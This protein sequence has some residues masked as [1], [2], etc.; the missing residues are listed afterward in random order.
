MPIGVRVPRWSGCVRLTPC[1]ASTSK[2]MLL[3]TNRDF[4]EFVELLNSNGVRFLIVGGHAVALHGYPR[5]TGDLDVWVA[6]DPENA[7]RVT[8]VLLEFGFGSLKFSAQDFTRPGYAIQLGRPPYRI[9]ILT[10]IDAVAFSP[11]YRRR[12]TVRAGRLTIPFIAL[13]DLLR[14]K[15][16]TGRPQD[17]ADVEKLRPTHKLP[18]ART[19]PP[20]RQRAAPSSRAR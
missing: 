4:R 12:R 9:D 7:E 6:T 3:L 1:A 15:R 20:R 11:A 18:P 16:A 5:F 10:S 8:K 2:P 14:N 13:G 19:R 17:L